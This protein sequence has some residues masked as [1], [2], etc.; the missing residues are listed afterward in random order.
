MAANRQFCILLR[1]GPLCGCAGPAAAHGWASGCPSAV[2]HGA[3]GLHTAH[4]AR[5]LPEEHAVL[6]FLFIFTMFFGGG[7]IPNYLLI[8][9]LGLVDNLLSLIFPTGLS[10]FNMILMKTYFE[11]LPRELSEAATIDGAGRLNQ[12]W[13]ITLPGMFPVIG[14]QLIFSLGNLVKDDF[15]QIYTMTGGGNPY[16]VETTEVIGTVVFKAIGTV[17][18]YGTATAMGLMQSVVALMLVLSSNIIVKKIGLQG[19]F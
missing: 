17:S 16:L 13:H 6:Y 1:S 2:R 10:M 12:L 8:K 9:D 19:M 15:D 14:I 18:A 3:A 7:L 4:Q 5:R 11:G